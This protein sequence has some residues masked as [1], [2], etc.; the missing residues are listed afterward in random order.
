[1]TET[2][3]QSGGR[4]ILL[5]IAGLPVTMILASTWLWYF[6]ERGDV[7]IIGALGTANS[8]ELLAEPINIRELEFEATDGSTVGLSGIEP[9][10]TML[11]VNDGA[12]C[13][14]ACNELLYVTR[15]IRIA[16]GR[17][18]QRTQRL[19]IVDTPI[20][21]IQSNV[22]SGDT[23]GPSDDMTLLMP[24]LEDDHVDLNVWRREDQAVL[25]EGQSEPSAW[26]LVDPSG[27]VMMRYTTDVN[28]KDVIGDIKFLL[29]NSGG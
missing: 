10:W 28:Y 17:D 15:Q 12:T 2:S 25:P 1:V 27:W 21:L 13:D 18:Y 9:K 3:N 19:L 24:Q 5:L 6:V 11:L 20:D 7:D 8:G 16:I 4:A 29:K 22:D 26:Y 14:A 23:E